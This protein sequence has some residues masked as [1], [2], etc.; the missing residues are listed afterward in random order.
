MRRPT[1]VVVVAPGEGRPPGLGSLAGEAEVHVA[2]TPAEMGA[3]IERADVLRVDDFRT[4]LVRE[5]WPRARRVRWI[6]ASSAG[7]DAVLLPGVEDRG[8]TVT[9]ARG[10]FDVGIAEWVLGVMLLFAKDL[11]TT[12]DLQARREW[13][14]RETELLAGRRLLVV[15]P[16]SIGRRIGALARAVGMRVAGVGRSERRDDA[17]FGRVAPAGELHAHLGAADFVAVATPLT[18]ETRGLIDAAAFA[19]MRPGARFINVGRGAVVDEGALLAALRAGRLAGAALDVF[20][21]EPLP[22]DHPFWTMSN[23]VVSPH[24]SGDFR[25]WREALGALFADN[26]RR[27]R[28]GAPLRN[29]VREGRRR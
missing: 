9:N 16:G 23:V 22:R 25:G 7:V 1:V 21:E 11:R 19:A 10:V 24:M 15:G 14:H 27:W 26:F 29:V 3:V 6:H 5:A 4:T 13:R 12:L 20:V 28:A 8:V 2:S 17:V 18:P